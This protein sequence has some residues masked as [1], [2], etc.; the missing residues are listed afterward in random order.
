MDSWSKELSVSHDLISYEL[1]EMQNLDSMPV[2]QD[3]GTIY[4]GT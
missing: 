2:S 1:M 4:P 3:D